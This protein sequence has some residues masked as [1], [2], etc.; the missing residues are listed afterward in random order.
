[1]RGYDVAFIGG[2]IVGLALT[3]AWLSPQPGS[4]VLVLDKEE[5]LDDGHGVINCRR[6]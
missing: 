2:G 1:M 5:R 4:R 3:D 6:R